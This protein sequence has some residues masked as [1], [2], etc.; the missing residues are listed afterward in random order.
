MRLEVARSLAVARSWGRCEG[1]GAYGQ[2][3]DGHHRQ[4][5]GSGGV[6]GSAAHVAND[7]RNLLA[8]CRTCHDRTEDAEHWAEVIG[9]GWRIPKWVEDPL[10]VPA[11]LHTVQGEGWWLLTQD[12]GYRWIDWP[13]DRRLTYAA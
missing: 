11:Y 1:C 8:L 9:L 7:V 6:Y 2:H 10:T 12:A 3:L 5:R 4:A 13:A